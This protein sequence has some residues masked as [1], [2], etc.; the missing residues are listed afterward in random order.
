MVRGQY[1]RFAS[2]AFLSRL[3]YT[4]PAKYGAQ[5]ALRARSIGPTLRRSTGVHAGQSNLRFAEAQPLRL[6][7]STRKLKLWYFNT[8]GKWMLKMFDEV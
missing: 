1:R 5:R 2:S 8:F 3:N 7:I 6:A 4:Q